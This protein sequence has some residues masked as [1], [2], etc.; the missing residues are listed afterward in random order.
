MPRR[1]PRTPASAGT[2]ATP[3]PTSQTSPQTPTGQDGVVQRKLHDLVATQR[4]NDAIRLREQALR[5]QPALQLQPSEADLW[6][7]EGRQAVKQGQ[8]KRAET[9]L[10][11]AIALGLCG[12]PEYLLA[13]L[14]LTH[15]EGRRGLTLL[16]QA[17]EEGRLPATH[18]GAYL[19]LLLIEGDTETV[20]QLLRTMPERFQA[21]QIHW[22]SGV[23]HLLEGD[24]RQAQRQFGLMAGP[25]T[26]GDHVMA[27]KAWAALESGDHA[28]A[29][30]SLAAADAHPACIALS[31]DQ[32]ARSG[33]RPSAIYSLEQ[34]TLPGRELV[35]ALE[36]L[37]R[38][39]QRQWRSAG[40][41]LMS[42]ERILLKALPDLGSL[43]RTLLLLAGQQ[44]VDQESPRDA[45][46]CWRTIVERPQFDPELA[47]R[48]Y[49][50]LDGEGEEEAIQA[51][52]LVSQLL[53]WLRRTA[54]EAPA[55]WPE[56]KLSTT[57]ARLLC[58]QIDQL[59]QS[60]GGQRR[61]RACLDQASQLAPEH[62]DV[63]GR[64]G[65][66]AMLDEDFASAIP[67]LQ[68][69]IAGGCRSPLA[70][71]MLKDALESSGEE[72]ASEQLQQQHGAQFDD[73]PALRS[74]IEE[75]PIW[76]DI[77][78]QNDVHDIKQH[79]SRTSSKTPAL[80]AL[81]VFFDHAI[82]PQFPD[83]REKTLIDVGPFTQAWE[84]LLAKLPPAEQVEALTTL[85]TAMLRFVPLTR[86]A[87]VAQIEAR[88]AELE[89]LAAD[90][91]APHFEQTL[92]GLLLVCGLRYRRIDVLKPRVTP[93][94]RRSSQPDRLVARVVLDLAVLGNPRP[95]KSIVSEYRIRDRQNPLLALA[96]ALVEPKDGYTYSSL[97]RQA[98]EQARIQ[99]DSET[100]A[101]CRREELWDELRERRSSELFLKRRL[102]SR[103]GQGDQGLQD[104]D[105][106]AM[107]QRLMLEQ[108]LEPL[109]PLKLELIMPM[110]ESVIETNLEE[111][112]AEG[113]DHQAQHDLAEEMLRELVQMQM[114]YADRQ[115]RSARGRRRSFMDL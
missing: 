115:Q 39:R 79:L 17:F 76:L 29:R 73:I 21:P 90:R 92:Q 71:E 112:R 54:R 111:L 78:T 67:L 25:A 59:I 53:S 107:L 8:R 56:P 101:A 63:V 66:V 42:E 35:L 40:Q 27:W 46:R 108:N 84:A 55:D 44:A 85:L 10:H 57:Q 28:A 95:W 105:L 2:P 113:G 3:S 94:L 96:L 20:R 41:L 109:S 26:P 7:L 1:R 68:Q 51:E 72:E 36:L 31:L 49:P 61:V 62:A 91:H 23:L 58:W 6:C 16:Q 83:H 34:R 102:F 75:F 43:R 33:D 65:M 24:A 12:E 19:K 98:F 70:Y 22:A 18:A 86:K 87:M 60:F 99:Q 4:Y 15:G 47:L 32:L 50:V 80:Q 30:Q 74:P 81:R 38:L 64:R 77:V 82:P 103:G 37:H 93:L 52:R 13:R 45:I 114:N 89:A 104:L 106:R 97:R 14:W 9:A 100:L 48:L 11:K 5:R 110:V 69:A 88:Q